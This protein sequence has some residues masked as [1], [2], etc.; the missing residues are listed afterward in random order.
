MAA[1][2]N[3]LPLAGNL[4]DIETLDHLVI[5]RGRFVSLKE[6]GKSW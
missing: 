2:A 4:L 5:S 1:R 6:K 3:S